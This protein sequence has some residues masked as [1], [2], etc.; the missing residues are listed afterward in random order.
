MI[1]DTDLAGLYEVETKV[2]IQAVKR[3]LDR[4]PED[5]MFQLSKAE[6]LELVLQKLTPGEYQ[7]LRSQIVTSKSWGGRRYLPYAFTEQ[8][9]AM[10]SSVLR[11]S[12]AVQ[13]NIEIM[14]TFIRLRQI[15]S[16]NVE[17]AKKLDMLEK[18]YDAQFRVVFEAIRRLMLPPEAN[19][20][21]LGFRK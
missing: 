6:Y 12:R 16:S 1:L 5:F 14:R 11:S 20:R 4:F 8:G 13:V 21:P 15:L 2:L 17:L 3:N 10:L 18:K 9:V 7:N 19:K